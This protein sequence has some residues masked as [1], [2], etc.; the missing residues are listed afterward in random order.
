MSMLA[1]T[2]VQKFESR[3]SSKD[4]QW[5]RSINADAL[6]ES[7]LQSKGPC[8]PDEAQGVMKAILDVANEDAA[9][10]PR[11]TPTQLTTALR[12]QPV[13]VLPGVWTVYNALTVRCRLEAR[14]RR[15]GAHQ[16]RLPLRPGLKQQACRP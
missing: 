9:F 11:L 12:D 14:L 2:V 3:L 5:M 4:T 7:I 1:R 15:G 16:R 13:T 8:S 10:L 6:V